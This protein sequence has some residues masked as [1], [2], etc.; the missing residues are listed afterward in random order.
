MRAIFWAM[1]FLGQ[2]CVVMIML[3]GVVGIFSGVTMAVSA[4]LGGLLVVIP[5]IGLVIYLF[6]GKKTRVSLQT[7]KVFYIGEA[8]KILL[9]VV[10]MVL[11]LR[12][13]DVKLAPLL[14]GFCGTYSVYFLSTRSM[15]VN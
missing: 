15:H 8:L 5:N 9:M 12:Y 14:I 4:L 13:V 2:Q 6:S 1:R 10:L 11:M 7:M 3:T